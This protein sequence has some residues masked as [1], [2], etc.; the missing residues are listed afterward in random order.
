MSTVQ[1]RGLAATVQ[2]VQA[3]LLD[4]DGPV[5][6]IFAG[7]PAPQIAQELRELISRQG[8][9]VAPALIG[10]EDPLQVL[11]VVARLYSSD[12]TQ[13]VAE[14][15][16]A[17]EL[18]A[19]ETAQPTPGAAE[20]IEAARS[21]QRNLSIVSN[22]SRE[23]VTAYLECH[24]LGRYFDR[25]VGRYDD[26]NPALLKPSRH[27]VDLATVGFETPPQAT[28]LV[29][30]SVTDIEAAQ[31]TGIGSI[32]YANKAGKDRAFVKAGAT[33]VIHSMDELAAALRQAPYR[34]DNADR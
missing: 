31:A 8:H 13:F 21:T 3:L 7:Y 22:N 15:F 29:G 33:A 34:E 27:L 17:A 32:G 26:M 6:D 10:K 4:F 23:A 25:V 18:A 14:A 20:V 11:R 24:D 19:V 9:P 28:S 1:A 16:R 30:D 12:V 2:Q 5:C